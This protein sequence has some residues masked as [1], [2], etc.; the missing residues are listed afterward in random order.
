[1]DSVA[2]AG[3][4]STHLQSQHPGERDREQAKIM[5]KLTEIIL[6]GELNLVLESSY[7]SVQLTVPRKQND[8]YLVL[9]ETQL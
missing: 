2:W 5:V 1:M 8:H 9:S 7:Q 4:E 3:C 6:R